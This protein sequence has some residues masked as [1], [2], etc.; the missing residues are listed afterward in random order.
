MLK[1][2][3]L[4][5]KQEMEIFKQE[6]ELFHPLQD[7]WSKNLF[8]EMSLIF[9]KEFIIDFQNRKWNY[10]NRKWNYFFHFQASD[11]INSFTTSFPYRLSKKKWGDVLY[12]LSWLPE[13]LEWKFYIFFNS[14]LLADYE[15]DLNSI[16][17]SF[18]RQDI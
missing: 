13:W 8:Y 3:E 9:I 12:L 18:L 11:Q 1:S 14:P 15:N 4:V 10:P 6:M 7:L 16:P 5:F 2:Q 17:R